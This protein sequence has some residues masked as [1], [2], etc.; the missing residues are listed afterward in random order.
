M[1]GRLLALSALI[2]FMV[3]LGKGGLGG[4][5]AGIITPL[6][7]LILPVREAVVL[8][9]P[10]LMV[11]DWFAVRAYW[12]GLGCSPTQAPFPPRFA[13]RPSRRLS[14]GESAR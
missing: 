2:A 10:Y 9:M 6:V 11:G 1:D 13:E 4:A 12:G 3:G 14:A 7:S 8:V 5:F